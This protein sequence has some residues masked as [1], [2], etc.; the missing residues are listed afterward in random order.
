MR[1]GGEPVDARARAAPAVTDGPPA[2]HPQHAGARLTDLGCT[3]EARENANA[4]NRIP[5]GT[6][7]SGGAHPQLGKAPAF[8]PTPNATR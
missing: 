7:L 4:N 5:S 8:K 1:A 2:R 3:L 6:W